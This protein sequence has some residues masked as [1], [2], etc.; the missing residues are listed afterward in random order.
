MKA[1]AKFL[2]IS[3]GLASCGKSKDKSKEEAASPV[4]DGALIRGTWVYESVSIKTDTADQ[5]V[6][7]GLSKLSLLGNGTFSESSEAS[8]Y[9]I[10]GTVLDSN[11]TRYLTGKWQVTNGVLLLTDMYVAATSGNCNGLSYTP[12]VEKAGSDQSRTA[13]LSGN[14]LL[15]AAD[16]SYT[17]TDGT[18]KTGRTTSTLTKESEETWD[19][20]GLNP[21]FSGTWKV[22]KIYVDDVCGLPTD[23]H[24]ELVLKGTAQ[25]TIAGATYSS[26]LSGFAVGSEPGC[27]AT[28][29]GTVAPLPPYDF[30]T[31]QVTVSA[32][33]GKTSVTPPGEVDLLNRSLISASG[34]LVSYYAKGDPVT[35][36]TEGR[37]RVSQIVV[38]ER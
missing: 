27:D 7:N 15:L 24:T 2:I 19:G 21:R 37:D 36:C 1:L 32:D 13:G 4:T 33:C 9:S 38:S 5:A 23:S 18:P 30:K 8:T 11:C 10:A 17:G 22:N 28:D 34:K 31:S 35:K 25:I 26:I 20:S 6:T 3:V 16:F 14:K 29:N 12:I